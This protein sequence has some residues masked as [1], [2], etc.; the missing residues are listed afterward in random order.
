MKKFIRMLKSMTTRRQQQRHCTCVWLTWNVMEKHSC[1]FF[2]YGS[3]TSEREREERK[4]VFFPISSSSSLP[5]DFLLFYFIFCYC[6]CKVFPSSILQ[7]KW[8]KGS[9]HFILSCEISW[10][11]RERKMPPNDMKYTEENLKMYVFP[12]SPPIHH[13]SL[14]LLISLFLLFWAKLLAH[15]GTYMN[16]K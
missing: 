2:M 11:E 9:S 1:A 6:H 15:F 13:P 3:R 8:K 10:N 5:S 7:A 12:P 14:I 4:K 16:F